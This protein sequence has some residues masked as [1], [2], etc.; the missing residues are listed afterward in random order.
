MIIVLDIIIM[1]MSV[2]KK[3]RV[4]KISF[5]VCISNGIIKIEIILGFDR[6]GTLPLG[7]V[8]RARDL[9]LRLAVAVAASH[10]VIVH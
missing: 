2:R 5:P 1:N 8:G 9:L 6:L 4:T 10:F 7:N 3:D